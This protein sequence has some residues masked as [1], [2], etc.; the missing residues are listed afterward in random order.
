MGRTSGAK[1]AGNH[2]HTYITHRHHPLHHPLPHPR[3]PTPSRQHLPLFLRVR[4]SRKRPPQLPERVDRSAHIANAHQCTRVT[5]HQS[6]LHISLTT[7]LDQHHLQMQAQLMVQQPTH[8]RDKE[9]GQLEG[10]GGG[11]AAGIVL[12]SAATAPAANRATV[13][14]RTHTRH[15]GG[16][17]ESARSPA[18]PGDNRPPHARAHGRRHDHSSPGQRRA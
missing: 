10:Q 5:P 8:M 7:R 1:N 3:R 14:Q 13:Q 9:K 6:T 2:S 11:D 18:L 12:V 17:R 16:R 4:D 15:G